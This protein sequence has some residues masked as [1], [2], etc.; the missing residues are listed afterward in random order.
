MEQTGA[1]FYQQIEQWKEQTKAIDIMCAHEGKTDT[2][3]RE[4]SEFRQKLSSQVTSLTE[5]N[6]HRENIH[7]LA[8]LPIA[9][10]E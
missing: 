3:T 5:Q 9:Y 2:T 8:L 7:K 4:V 1:V 6:Y 10:N